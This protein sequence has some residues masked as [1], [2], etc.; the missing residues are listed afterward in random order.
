MV[1]EHWN[2]GRLDDLAYQVKVISGV[3]GTVA[4]HTAQIDALEDGNDANRQALR[5]AIIEFRRSLEAFDVA[6]DRKVERLEKAITSQQ[7]AW[8]RQRE[9]DIEALRWSKGQWLAAASPIVA[10]LALVVAVLQ[11]TS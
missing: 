1:P 3:A 8:E 11:A 2:D 7:A 6:C 10:L 9:Q 4:T 5:D